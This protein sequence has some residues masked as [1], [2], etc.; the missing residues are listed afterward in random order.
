MT[1]F[2]DFFKILRDSGL[3]TAAFIIGALTLILAIVGNVKSII[4]LST[5]KAIAL[6]T[7][8]IGFIFLS[9]SGYFIS[10]Q[11]TPSTQII[12]KESIPVAI[13]SP[14]VPI[15]TASLPTI[16]ATVVADFPAP[17]PIATATSLPS[18]TPRPTATQVLPTPTPSL[19]FV[20]R[21]ETGGYTSKTYSLTL[22]NGE[23]VVGQGYG[24]NQTRGGCVAFLIRGPT[25]LSFL[26]TD[27]AWRQYKNAT[28]IE[29]GESLLQRE[30]DILIG[31]YECTSATVKV[32]RLP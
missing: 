15:A 30:I 17:V 32:I 18:P 8:G 9:I 4:E 19:S 25:Q 2:V 16:R 7:V 21:E 1:V 20:K 5:A 12:V 28:S 14:A 27:G 29:Q 11:A 24:F 13:A 22:S 23:I 10:L 31:Q 3:L 26:L 6:G